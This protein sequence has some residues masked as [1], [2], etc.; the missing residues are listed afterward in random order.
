MLRCLSC[1]WS[2][3]FFSSIDVTLFIAWTLV[4]IHL[5]LLTFSM[6][7]WRNWNGQLHCWHLMML[8]VVQWKRWKSFLIMHNVRKQQANSMLPFSLARAMR[9]V[10][11]PPHL[12]MFMLLL[13]VSFSQNPP[14]L[15]LCFQKCSLV[16]SMFCIWVCRSKATESAE[17]VDMGSKPAGW[18]SFLPSNQWSGQCNSWGACH[19]ILSILLPYSIKQM[20]QFSLSCIHSLLFHLLPFRLFFCLS[21]VQ[22]LCKI[23]CNLAP[24]S[25]TSKSMWLPSLYVPFVTWARLV[26][27]NHINC[28]DKLMVTCKKCRVFIV[29]RQVWYFRLG[30]NPKW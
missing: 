30:I 14:S 5:D 22:Q 6:H 26:Q 16:F 7:F 3:S 25:L 10:N 18:K 19:I 2:Y 9:K 11:A 13:A 21:H 1:C 23:G 15:N 24:I 8:Q 12:S 27:G 20:R 17:D 28:R 4:L 29:G